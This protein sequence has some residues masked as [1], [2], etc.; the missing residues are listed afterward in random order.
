[1]YV[2][3]GSYSQQVVMAP[4]DLIINCMLQ[5]LVEDLTN[6]LFACNLVDSSI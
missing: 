1:M 2:A 4:S 5:I 6:Q 3:N